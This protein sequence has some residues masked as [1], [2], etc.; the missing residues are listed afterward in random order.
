MLLSVYII[1]K[2]EEV[3]V[4][5]ALESVRGVADEIVVV[6]SGSTDKTITIVKQYTDRVYTK[7]FR[8]DFSQL[9][10]FALSK[11]R[12]EWVLTLDA[13]ERLSEGLKEKIPELIADKHVDGYWF[14]RKTF[15]SGARY[16]KYGVFYPDYQLRLFRNKKEYRYRGAVHEQLTIPK[17]K[18]REVPY[19]V[20]HYPTHPKYDRFSSIVNMTGYMRIAARSYTKQF[21]TATLVGKAITSFIDIFLGG[22]FRGKGI[23]DG[24]AGFRA[25]LIF[26][27]SVSG[28]WALAC[29]YKL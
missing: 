28:S 8:D 15:I 20:L 22:L 5:E 25:H 24:W 27:L 17:E 4:G 29:V 26:A 12:G 16:L 1:T 23:L 18:T 11:L 19:D 3:G 21:D 10:N 2:N 13:D 14:A 9:R 6:D 7:R